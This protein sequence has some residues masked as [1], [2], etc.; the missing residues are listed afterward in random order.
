MQTFAA[1]ADDTRLHMVEVLADGEQSVGELVARFHLSQPAIS[2]HL[3]VLR[4][5]GLVSVRADGQRRLYRLEAGPLQAVDAWLTRY[6]RFWSNQLDALERHLADNPE[7]PK[8]AP[9][10]PR[11]QR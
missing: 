6:R 1:L 9:K 7:L 4:D 2:Q 5:A 3:K 8:P 11:R 10:I